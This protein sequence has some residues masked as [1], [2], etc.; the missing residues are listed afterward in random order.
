[1]WSV[2]GLLYAKRARCAGRGFA[3]NISA[4]PSLCPLLPGAE[5]MIRWF[6]LRLLVV[7]L[8]TPTI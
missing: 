1:M 6:S 3:V 5:L 4:V 7:L 8:D 2:V